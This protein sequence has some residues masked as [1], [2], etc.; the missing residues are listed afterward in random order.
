M[1]DCSANRIFSQSVE[2]LLFRPLLRTAYSATPARS[3]RNLGYALRNRGLELAQQGQLAA[4]TALLEEAVTLIPDDADVHRGLGVA[5]WEQGALAQ[6]QAHLERSRALAPDDR[7][8]A[9]LLDR[10]NA[11]PARP[12]IGDRR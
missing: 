4:A 12:P 11:D 1:D 10:L 8:T 7:V 2:A 3:R 5:R 9:W 6:A